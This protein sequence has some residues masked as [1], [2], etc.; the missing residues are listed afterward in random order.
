MEFPSRFHR[1]REAESLL[2]CELDTACGALPDGHRV[3]GTL[4]LKIGDLYDAMGLYEKATPFIL[5]AVNAGESQ[6]GESDPAT[7]KVD[8]KTGG[9]L[10]SDRR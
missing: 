10:Q 6:M 5:Q 2:S 8:K 3:T 9:T 7:I 4:M 1:E